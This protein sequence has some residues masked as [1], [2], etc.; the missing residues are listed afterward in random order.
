VPGAELERSEAADG[1]ADLVDECGRPVLVARDLSSSSADRRARAD[2][3]EEV[4]TFGGVAPAA[5]DATDDV[6]GSAAGSWRFAA[7]C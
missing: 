7:G 6:V 4:D 3:L 1:V 5:Q 2:D